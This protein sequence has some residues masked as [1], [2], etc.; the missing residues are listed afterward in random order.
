M[1]PRQYGGRAWSHAQLGNWCRELGAVSTG[2]RAAVTVQSMIAA[3]LARWG[4]NQARDRVLPGLADGSVVAGFCL[5]EPGTGSDGA[6]VQTTAERH[7]GSW[8]VNGTKLWVTGGEWASLLLVIARAPE[9]PVAVL[10][11]AAAEGVRRQPVTDALVLR[12]A[13]LA[14][15]TFDQVVVP[16]DNVIGQPGYGFSHVANVAL[17]NGRLTVAA[18]C[19]GMAEGCL[20]EAVAHARVRRQGG[21]TLGEYQLVQRLLARADAAVCSARLLYQ[22]AAT[23]L[24]EGADDA[25]YRTFLAKYTASRAADEAADCAVQ[26]LGSRAFRDD[27]LVARLAGDARVMRIIEGTDEICESVIG[28]T[29]LKTFR[30]DGG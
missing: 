3:A 30:R 2:Q 17:T 28:E 26:V 23:G 4:T 29:L 9:G 16:A 24:D 22:W 27:N 1:I 25:A 6:C 5:T 8:V 19:A 12:D 10:V 15:I 11:D 7:A 13:G 14:D 21:R 20:A 18:G